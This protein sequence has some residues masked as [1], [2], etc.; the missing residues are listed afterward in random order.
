MSKKHNEL[1]VGTMIKLH[2]DDSIGIVVGIFSGSG[3][4]SIYIIE[5]L[6][7][8]DENSKFWQS[9]SFEVIG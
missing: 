4:G 8:H 7:D 2:C 5:W 3:K 9:H 6:V 1:P